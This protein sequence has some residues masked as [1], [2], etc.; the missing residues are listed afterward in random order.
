MKVS[1]NK[2]LT[3]V[4]LSI[5]AL[6]LLLTLV[7]FAT[8]HAHP[9]QGTRKADPTPQSIVSSDTAAFTELG[10][11]RALTKPESENE[12]GESVVVTPWLSYPANDKTFYEEL[13]QKNRKIKLLIAEYFSEYTKKELLL[14]PEQSIKD[15]L[16][17][18]INAELVLG[19]IKAIYFSE[20]IFL[21]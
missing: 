5:I 2:A 4:A 14:L 7:L 10:Q 15:D 9:G 3:C 20:Y 18:Q 17:H 16:L 19:K 1:F 13:S 11:L 12:R 8:G 21:E 6:I